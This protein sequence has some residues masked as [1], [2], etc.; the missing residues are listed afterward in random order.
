MIAKRML[1]LN[2]KSLPFNVMLTGEKKV[3]Y[4]DI[5]KWMNTRLFHKDGSP[6]QFDE[7]RFTLG[8]GS[9][10][11]YFICKFSGLKKVR[12]VSKK[13]TNGLEVRFKGLR[14]AIRLGKIT[15]TGNI[16]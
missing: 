3:E 14:W 15:K 1:Q 16:K 2:L 5:K 11:P 12:N 4:R 10:Q 13:Y 9:S 8:Y 6:K 7:V